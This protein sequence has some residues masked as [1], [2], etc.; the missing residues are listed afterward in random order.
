MVKLGSL[1]SDTSEIESLFP[2]S[3]AALAG[4]HKALYAPVA[5]LVKKEK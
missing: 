2:I 1:K 3:H 5:S 4:L